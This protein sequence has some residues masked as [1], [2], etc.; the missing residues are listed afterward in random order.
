MSHDSSYKMEN[1]E[2][3]NLSYDLSYDLSYLDWGI[4]CNHMQRLNKLVKIFQHFNENLLQQNDQTANGGNKLYP[5]YNLYRL[6]SSGVIRK[7]HSLKNKYPKKRNIS[8]WIKDGRRTKMCTA[9]PGWQ[10]VSFRRPAYKS[11]MHILK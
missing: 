5:Y 9:R 8:K 3:Y 2:P 7:A 4:T 11:S 6:Y 10:T 1:S